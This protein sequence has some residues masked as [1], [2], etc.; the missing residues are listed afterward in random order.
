MRM[1]VVLLLPLVFV[2]LLAT[3][4]TTVD[5]T[6]EQ[7]AGPEPVTDDRPLPSWNR[8]MEATLPVVKAELA[9]EGERFRP[10]AFVL[11]RR[12]GVRGVHI[13]PAS[14]ADDAERIELIFQSLE[15]ILRGDDVV[16]LVVYA[17]GEGQLL[18]TEHRSDMVVAHLEHFSGRALLRRFSYERNGDS[19]TFGAED[20]D[21]TNTLIMG[22]G[23]Q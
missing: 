19:V 20:V 7:Q 11:S 4:C 13:D 2:V 22:E 23:D 1:K 9:A 10:R 3:G 17:T 6:M 21:R 12:G 18:N 14:G 8:L 15:A 16:A 5:P